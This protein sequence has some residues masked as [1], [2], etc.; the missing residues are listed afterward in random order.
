MTIVTPMK[1]IQ[2][3]RRICM[4]SV[5]LLLLLLTYV[6]P[7]YAQMLPFKTFSSDDG[8]IQSSVF[9][10]Y[11]DGKG[12]LWLGTTAG[13]SRY[14]GHGFTNF[15]REFGLN[16]PVVRT[17]K[18]DRKGLIWFGTG[19]GLSSFDGTSFKNYGVADGLADPD[20]RAL[21]LDGDGSLWVGTYGGLSVI[22]DDRLESLGGLGPASRVIALALDRNDR[23][24]FGS[25]EGLGVI[26]D[27][28]PQILSKPAIENGHII[29][30]LHIDGKNRFWLGIG[31]RDDKTFPHKT[32][33]QG[34]YLWDP[35]Q[36]EELVPVIP[37]IAVTHIY[38]DRDNRIWAATR[39]DGVFRY[40]G[41]GV[42]PL[43]YN[44]ESGLPNNSINTVFQDSE[45]SMWFGT[46]AG[47]VSHLKNENFFNYPI[48]NGFQVPS[49]YSFCQDREG[50]Y[51][52]GTNGAGVSRL[53][54]GVFTAFTT[55]DGLAHDK[56]LSSM[57]DRDG[58]L[59]LGTLNGVSLRE[60]GTFRNLTD[61]LSSSKIF[62]IHQSQSG[63]IWMATIDGIS[64]YSNGA[65]RKFPQ[66]EPGRG[67]RFNAILEDRDGVLWFAGK[68][69]LRYDGQ[70]FEPFNLGADMDDPYINDITQDS[71]GNV[72]LAMSGGLVRYGAD[73]RRLFT[74][75]DGLSSES[76]KTVIEDENGVIWIGTIRGLNRFNGESFDLF[77][78]K[79][80]ILSNEF[81]RGADFKDDQG[82]I[83]FGTN[84]GITIFN[85]NATIKPN[86]L[87]PPIH[88][89]GFS[90][91]GT[92]TEMTPNL[93]LPYN[94]NYVAFDFSGI[95]FTAPEELTYYFR[96]EGLE[97]E[98]T[99]GRV[100]M[101]QYG[102]LA[103]GPYTFRVKA[104]NGDRVE[105]AT[106]AT[107]SFV[108]IPPIWQRG[109][110][111]VIELLLVVAVIYM[112]FRAQVRKER[113]K[114]EARSAIEANKAKSAFLAHMS[115]ELRTPLNAIL[116][117]SEILEEDFR[118]NRHPDYVEDI[119]KVQFSAHHL[120]SLINNILDI[121]K[122]DAGKMMIFYENFQPG[123]IIEMV[124][125]T[126][127]PLV[128]KNDNEFIVRCS[129]VGM[130]RADKAK[131]RQVLL[132]LISNAS[133]FTQD[134]QIILDISKSVED[135]KEWILFKVIDNGIGMTKEE[136]DLLFEE[137]IQ[138]SD[139]ISSQ[140]GGTGLGLVISRRF[141]QIMQ[142]NLSAESEPG[143]GSVFT[144]RLPAEGGEL[145]Q[146][147]ADSP[148]V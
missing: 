100:G 101:R 88:I 12:Y 26:K 9:A 115:H 102:N 44:R 61:G 1:K 133:K 142:G 73:G 132:N 84:K 147:A 77:T 21:I 33:R 46:Y 92:P 83:W 55:K 10:L 39:D 69:I 86:L 11:Q 119:Q 3:A 63:D 129:D 66:G 110:F 18:E 31:L 141:C 136:Q 122:I 34:F 131:L 139:S 50:A 85:Y 25:T 52:I 32:F 120:L 48:Q 90:I 148:L 20:V 53:K 64:C 45:G 59:W 60:N 124:R 109:W 95:T 82:N 38:E 81:M 6:V 40:S 15:G 130:I 140:F 54:D 108:I 143:K 36:S 23:V 51:W 123:V 5:P 4:K 113:L 30:A 27:G 146:T 8:L 16:D 58:R 72:W 98:W 14:D 125:N 107:Y 118:Y 138:A 126:V 56:V 65:F 134:G 105:S 2:P 76:C 28:K 37:D 42:P 99:S 112:I 49:S 121:S 13:V 117:Y 91:Y 104:I 135:G 7:G 79:D 96:L 22:R 17:I 71:E 111:L 128:R 87:P 74:Q 106:E 127:M 80:G 24:W 137:F 67:A 145:T 43:V 116:G 41:V 19:S 68:G 94:K 103:P 89:T 144:V 78:T 29:T 35:A 93:E 97:E 47:G 57:I 114:A 70:N 62:D 75:K